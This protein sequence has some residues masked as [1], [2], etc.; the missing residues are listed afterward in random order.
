[1]ATRPRSRAGALRTTDWT[2]HRM[3]D[4]WNRRSGMRA[5]T[6]SR[7]P[8]RACR[9]CATMNSARSPTMA[10]PECRTTRARAT[11]SSRASRGVP[12]A[13]RK[14]FAGSSAPERTWM[15]CAWT[16]TTSAGSRGSSRRGPRARP[17]TLHTIDASWKA[18]DSRKPRRV[19][20]DGREQ[21]TTEQRM[22]K[23]KLAVLAV[24]AAL[25]AAFFI[26]D[27]RQYI[28]LEFFQAKRAAIEAYRD[29]NPVQATLAFFA[30]YVAVTALSLP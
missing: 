21:K 7:A 8:T 3:R 13:A 11:G 20:S 1:M 23:G 10:R 24:I 14:G 19:R 22:S 26:F 29:A 17:R 9:R 15:C 2:I 30:V 5:W 16:T 27:L 25:V 18:R 6:S 4:G 12:I 28:S